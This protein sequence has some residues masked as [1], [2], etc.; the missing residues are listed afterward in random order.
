M[1]GLFIGLALA[2]VAAPALAQTQQQHDWCYS[3]TATDDQTIDGCTALI[4]SGR[5]STVG[6]AAAYDARAFAYNNKG[7]YDQVIADEYQSLALNP[8]SANAY[9]DRGSAYYH[10][11]FYDQAIADFTRSIALKPDTAGAYNNNGNAFAYSN[12]GDAYRLKGL[13]DPAIADYSQ[14]IAL[15]ADFTQ[16]YTGRAAA[17]ESKGMR[18]QAVADYRAA[19]KIDPSLRLSLDGLTRLGATP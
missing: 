7:L 16:A 12:R 17:Y 10:K 18:D 15:K 2:L 11:G 13:Y 19:L 5:E 6:Q 3:P 9:N 8:N 4:G 1:R 14:S